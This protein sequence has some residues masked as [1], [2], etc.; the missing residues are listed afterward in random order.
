[1]LFAFTHF[2]VHN[3]ES[4]ELLKGIGCKNVSSAGETRFDRVY[5]IATGAKTLPKVEG[6]S[7][8]RL[9][10]IAGSTWP[11]DEEFLINYINASKNNYKYII[12]AHE[13]DE[14]HI[15][16]IVDQIQKP[17]VR[18]T[19][20]SKEEIEVAEVLVNDCIGVLSAL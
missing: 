18:Y 17:W 14:N 15:K 4:E 5:S 8:G 11:K 1:M 20:A 2:F 19:N 12:A 13:V 6:F 16:N 10:L 9:V 3:Q 7:Q